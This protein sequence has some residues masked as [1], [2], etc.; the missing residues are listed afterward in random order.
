MSWR[1][2]Q[3]ETKK[4]FS[5]RVRE[6]VFS[7]QTLPLS[8]D[9]WFLHCL[10]EKTL[11][12]NCLGL[13]HSELNFI[14]G[15][16]PSERWEMMN[17]CLKDLRTLPDPIFLLQVNYTPPPPPP[18]LTAKNK[19]TTD[20]QPDDFIS[21]GW[22][23]V[24]FPFQYWTGRL[25]LTFWKVNR[26]LVTSFLATTLTYLVILMQY[27]WSWSYW[28]STLD[29]KKT[30]FFTYCVDIRHNFTAIMALK[31]IS[32]IHNMRVMTFGSLGTWMVRK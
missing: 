30:S 23:Q 17:W 13:F 32:S 27:T 4:Q 6:G 14:H 1:W 22:L 21:S 28:C 11:C 31:Y 24:I 18:R 3:R 2:V 9:V 29:L 8:S 7:F 25:P 15:C 16:L 12:H 19:K 10:L 26:E 5:Q 20:C